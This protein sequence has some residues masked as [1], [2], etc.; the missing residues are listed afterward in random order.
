M[1]AYIPNYEQIKHS[2]HEAVYAL[3]KKTVMIKTGEQ[4]PD[5]N[6]LNQDGKTISL[7]DFK[8][9][10]VILYFYPKDMTPGCTAQ[11][12]SLRDA[13]KSLKKAGY[14]VLGVSADTV[15]KHRQFADTYELPFDLLSDTDKSIIG[16]YGVWGKKK[17]MGREVEGIL[18][19]TF[20]INERGVIERI[21]DKVT[22][23]THAEQILEA[24]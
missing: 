13:E 10:K 23:K 22:T 19:T 8:G 18:R 24:V 7:A 15:K 2:G 16:L 6:A 14:V 3:S 17:F 9:K 11:A 12:C 1:A 20:I 21:I 5:F 4:A